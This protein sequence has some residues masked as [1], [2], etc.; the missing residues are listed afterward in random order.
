MRLK[1]FKPRD[2]VFSFLMRRLH[3]SAIDETILSLVLDK[4]I[5]LK[6]K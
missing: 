2:A 6:Q 3:N 5:F 1:C 4:I